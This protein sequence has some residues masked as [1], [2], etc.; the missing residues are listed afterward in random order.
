MDLS[1]YFATY[2]TRQKLL[3]KS[4]KTVSQYRISI[5]RFAEF[6][7]RAPL[8]SDINDE[9]IPAW[10]EHLLEIG[11]AH[12]TVNKHRRQLLA[13]ARHAVKKPHISK[14][15]AVPEITKLSELDSDPIIW[16]MEEMAQLI[17][18]CESIPGR[19]GNLL[20]C[21]FWPALVKTLL[22]TGARIG[23]MMQVPPSC[24]DQEDKLLLLPAKFQKQKRDQWLPL[25]DQAIAAIAK[26]YRPDAPW[27]FH[28]PFDRKIDPNFGTL[29]KHFREIVVAAGLTT[30]AGTFHRIR[31]TR[32]T[33]G[34]MASPGSATRDLGHSDPR[35]TRRYLSQK[36]LR[37]SRTVDLIQ[38]PSQS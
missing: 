34:E 15:S 30:E 2:Y 4:Q 8:V 38:F 22:V 10:F 37:P 17:V 33:Y 13:I 26:I 5:N 12:A 23:V 31:R 18:Y 7:Q 29:H 35:V 21:E 32:A 3:G 36:F 1:A 27:L 25:T 14:L 6:L 24:F 28:W 11:Q 19:I 20:A 16:T 9:L